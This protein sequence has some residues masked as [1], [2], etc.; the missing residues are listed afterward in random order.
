MQDYLELSDMDVD[1]A[2]SV[3]KWRLHMAPFGEN[4]RNGQNAVWCPLSCENTHLD[5]QEFVT[6]CTVMK[7]LF[8]LNGNHSDIYSDTWIPSVVAKKV[9]SITKYR[10]DLLY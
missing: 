3:I 6:N 8:D 7:S 9:H 5:S 2:K 4:F 10:E 1:T